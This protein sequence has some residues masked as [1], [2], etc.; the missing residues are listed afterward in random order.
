MLNRAYGLIRT[1][2]ARDD[3]RPER[4]VVGIVDKGACPGEN[5]AVQVWHAF[6]DPKVGAV[7]GRTFVSPGK[8][9]GWGQQYED[10]V[11]ADA[12]QLLATSRGVA[13]LGVTG[14][15]VRLSVL[16]RLGARPWRPG[17]DE[18]GDLGARVHR[19]GFAIHHVP[20]VAVAVGALRP[21]GLLLQRVRQAQAFLQAW[22]KHDRRQSLQ[23]TLVEQWRWL[24]RGAAWLFAAGTA[25]AIVTWFGFT[26]ARLQGGTSVEEIGHPHYARWYMLPPKVIAWQAP[27]WNMFAQSVAIW[28]VAL[29]APVPV[30]WGARRELSAAAL[31]RGALARPLMVLLW[32]VAFVVALGRQL[33]GRRT[34]RIALRRF[35]AIP[36]AAATEAA[37]ATKAAVF[38]D[39]TGRRRLRM[40]TVAYSIALAG[41]AYL[42]VF[43]FALI[44]RPVQPY[45]DNSVRSLF[46][47]FPRPTLTPDDEPDQLDPTGNGDSG[48]DAVNEVTSP[49]PSQSDTPDP[50]DSV[51]PSA[52]PDPTG[53]AQPTGTPNPTGS[54][55][56][57]TP[58]GTRGGTTPNPTPTGGGTTSGPTKKGVA[59]KA[60]G[61][62]GDTVTKP[63]ATGAAAASTNAVA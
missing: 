62:G 36:A 32:P 8:A 47:D 52:S 29:L 17:A 57:P 22:P 55:G 33:V 46:Q 30:W 61:T 54:T 2:A 16:H 5:L 31:V 12:T 24:R 19:L 15:F 42:L 18:G 63:P 26:A 41:T 4:I 45:V 13:R 3:V 50:T 43:A 34:W 1:R 49:E 7:Q 6:A 59:P 20:R 35:A 51:D 48:G 21:V 23:R 37:T 11:L 56:S 44:N 60:Q 38:V 9:F 58:T 25:A 28:L 40:W 53:S 10:G 14:S 27:S 39:A